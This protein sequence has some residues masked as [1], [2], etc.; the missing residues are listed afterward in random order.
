MSTKTKTTRY[1]PIEKRSKAQ[2]RIFNN[3]RRN[4]WDFHPVTRVKPSKKAY[5]RARTKN[6]RRNFDEQ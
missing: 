2:Q 3:I 6:E 5:S 1:V 4:F